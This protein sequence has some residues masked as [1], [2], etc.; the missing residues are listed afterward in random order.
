MPHPSSVHGY[1]MVIHPVWLRLLV[2]ALLSLPLLCIVLLSAP[3][4]ACWPFLGEGKQETVL[5]FVNQLTKWAKA[6]AGGRR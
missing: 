5:A 1:R 3:A 4:W 2:A 6:I